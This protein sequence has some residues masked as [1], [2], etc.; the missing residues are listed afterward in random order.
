MVT[1][2]S[3]SPAGLLRECVHC[4]LALAGSGLCY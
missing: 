2:R 3:I 4:E 1:M